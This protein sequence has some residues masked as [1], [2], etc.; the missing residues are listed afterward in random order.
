MKK[1]GF[2]LICVICLTAFNIIGTASVFAEEDYNYSEA[3]EDYDDEQLEE[4]TDNIEDTE[5]IVVP[6]DG[7]MEDDVYEDN[8]GAE[9]N[10]YPEDKAADTSWFNPDKQKKKYEISTEEELMGLAKL[11]NSRDMKWMVNEVYTFKG[12]TISLKKDIKLTSD[13]IP[14]GNSDNHAFEG[15]FEGNGHTISNITIK[16]ATTS[17][18]GIFGYVK[19]TINNL[20]I[21]G[22]IASEGNNI[23][24]LAGFIDENAVIQNCTAAVNVSGTSKVGGVVG[25][26]N[27]GIIINCHNVGNVKGLAKIG[28]VVGE[29]WGG[30][31]E[32]CSNDGTITSKGKGVGTYGTGGVA[33]RSVANTASI[34]NSFNKGS[35]KSNNECAG[36]IVG[37]ANAEGSSISNSYNAG[38]VRGVVKTKKPYGY[39]GGAVGSIGDDGVILSNCYNI[40][41][42]QGGL[43]TG[44]VLGNYTAS[45]LD[46]ITTF[47]S[48]N[49]YLDRVA[50]TGVGREKASKGGNYSNTVEPKSAAELRSPRMVA[51]LGPAFTA[52]ISGIYGQNKG[53]PI[54]LWQEN[55][56]I[57][58]DEI[59][60]KM[61]IKYK[62]E[63]KKLFKA[64]P[65]GVVS[66]Q[67]IIEILNPRLIFER[68][69]KDVSENDIELFQ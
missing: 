32:D 17:N 14:I 6:Q 52:D 1:R 47:I 9:E 7:A 2:I 56:N 11:V 3:E 53:F 19:G 64:H 5:P 41:V 43:Y 60:D 10:F 16:N 40:G 24:G 45:F 13:W 34:K 58:K 57:K 38:T 55:N 20:N 8:E 21:I 27:K 69:V 67:R 25:A 62:G 4:D 46:D 51:A 33:G 48:N 22:N 28:G 23:G 65:L 12:I 36:G 59:I 18:I 63:F 68:V 37:Y 66:G 15:N 42:L 50:P 54:L 35:I 44:G 29:N 49:Y 26:S 39:V 31:L 61:D 30:T